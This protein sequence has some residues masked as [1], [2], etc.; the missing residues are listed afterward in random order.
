MLKTVQYTLCLNI[1][2]LEAV[3]MQNFS[4]PGQSKIM[5]ITKCTSYELSD[6][7]SSFS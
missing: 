6:D 7:V 4:N 1:D 5:Q 2:I 3:E